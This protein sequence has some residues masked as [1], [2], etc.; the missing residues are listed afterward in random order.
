MSQKQTIS[1]KIGDKTVDRLE[2]WADEEGV[3]RSQATEHFARKGLDEN[4]SDSTKLN[5]TLG[6][7]LVAVLVL[8]NVSLPNSV[9]LAI[10][11]FLTAIY[12]YTVLMTTDIL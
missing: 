11:L 2:D 7:L 8:Q 9:S 4:E 12:G 1:A 5:I 6:A 10:S 3:S